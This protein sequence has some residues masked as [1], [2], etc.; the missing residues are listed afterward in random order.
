VGDI[1]TWSPVDANNNQNP[2]DGWPEGQAPS[3]VNNCARADKGAVRRWYEE[4]QWLNYGFSVSREA[5][6]KF[7]VASATSTAVAWYEVGRRIRFRESSS[8]VEGFGEVTEA[9][10]SGTSTN[11]TVSFDSSASLTSSLSAVDVGILTAINNAG[12]KGVVRYAYASSSVDDAV[13]TTTIT[14]SS[15]T[16]SITPKSSTN[17]IVV[18]AFC[19]FFVNSGSS[20]SRYQGKSDIY[21]TTGTPAS[22]NNGNVNWGNNLSTGSSKESSNPFVL[23]GSEIAGDTNLH[24]YVVRF[25]RN[26]S[27]GTASLLGAS[28]GPAI[29]LILELAV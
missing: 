20:I 28:E 6:D 17:R 9:S 2:P 11:V 18:L 29:M 14:Q 16:G 8:G 5:A 13:T 15:L 25:A 21:R 4:A 24:T 27:A 23:T 19:P 12:F 22:L 10:V 7:S 1:S 3:T 26:A